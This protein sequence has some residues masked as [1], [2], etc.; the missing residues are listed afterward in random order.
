MLLFHI[1][2][3][4]IIIY[5]TFG[6]LSHQCTVMIG[7]LAF[8]LTDKLQL[9]DVLS[10]VS[11]QANT[12][13]HFSLEEAEERVLDVLHGALH[14]RHRLQN[15]KPLPSNKSNANENKQKHRITHSASH[16]RCNCH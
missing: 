10:D 12:G 3:V 7:G 1:R 2:C 5:S 11:Q 9:V 15:P 6:Q 8:A 14:R 13:V 16:S 4:I